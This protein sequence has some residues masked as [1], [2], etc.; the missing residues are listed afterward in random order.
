M[1]VFLL[2]YESFMY[3]LVFEVFFKIFNFTYILQTYMVSVYFVVY[4]L[5]TKFV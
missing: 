1:K 5:I 4:I 3:L 2:Q